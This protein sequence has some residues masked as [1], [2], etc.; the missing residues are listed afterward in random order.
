MSEG[1]PIKSEKDVSV[2]STRSISLA[3]IT[4][5]AVAAVG[6]I[7][8]HITAFPISNPLYGLFHNNTDLIVY[9]GAGDT[10][11]GGRSLYRSTV[12]IGMYFTYPPFAAIVLS[13]LALIGQ[14]AANVL[15]F[16]AIVASLFAIILLGFRSLGH[17][18]GPRLVV[19]AVLL[20]ICATALEPVRTT[21]WL[22]QI[23]VFLML[24]VLVDLVFVRNTRLRGL[25][26]GLAAGIKLTPAFFLVYLAATRRWRALVVGAVTLGTTILIGALVVPGDARRYWTADVTGDA[27]IGRVDSPANQ[28]VKGFMSQMLAYFDVERFQ[29]P[30]RGGPYYAAPIW[31]WLP[32]AVAVGVLGVWAA[33]VAHRRGQELL[34]VSTTGMTASMVSPFSWGHHWVWF[35]PLLVVAIDYAGRSSS[36]RRMWWRWLAPVAIIALSFSYWHHWYGSGPRRFGADHAIAIG[37]FMMPRWPDPQWFDRLTVILYAGCYPLVMLVTCTVILLGARTRDRRDD[38]T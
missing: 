29:H 16:I 20:T 25:G 1:S 26:V 7:I 12:A 19:F 36:V 6:V 31:M 9:R 33:V 4:V 8:W 3:M 28:S 24:L 10:L 14:G 22:G 2:Q 32:V 15:W 5:A 37:L 38:F 35:V 13:P 11:I 27:R 18:I 34:A 21:I 17:R 23:N 30:M